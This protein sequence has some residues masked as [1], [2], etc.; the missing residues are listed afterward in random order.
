MQKYF[1]LRR[2]VTASQRV[3]RLTEH[4]DMTVLY[5]QQ[6]SLLLHETLFS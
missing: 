2:I 4:Y 6:V 3:Q 1:L 5:K